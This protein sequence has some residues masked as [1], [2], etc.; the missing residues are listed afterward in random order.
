MKT[1]VHTIFYTTIFALS[2]CGCV[3]PP[4]A[5]TSDAS[6]CGIQIRQMGMAV[7]DKWSFYDAML[8]QTISRRWYTLLDERGYTFDKHGKVV[9]HFVLHL[10]GRVSDINVAQNTSGE[11]ES[12]ICEKAV[13]DPA[14][15]PQWPSSMIGPPRKMEISFYF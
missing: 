14:P 11:V 9:L 5:G 6:R 8:T 3:T 10:D 4:K 7:D 2:L 15:F 13:H 12:V 1:R